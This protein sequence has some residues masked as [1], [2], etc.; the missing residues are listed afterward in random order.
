MT[1]EA[2]FMSA[3]PADAVCFIHGWQTEGLAARLVSAMRAMHGAGGVTVC[4]DCIRRAHA[5][6]RSRTRNGA[7]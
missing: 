4:A 7:A 6:A 3:R 5:D 1:R 2:I